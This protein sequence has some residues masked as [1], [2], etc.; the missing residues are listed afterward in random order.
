MS[1][2]T[3]VEKAEK[4]VLSLPERTWDHVYA[5]IKALEA[6][7]T[8]AVKGEPGAPGPAGPPG[9]AGINGAQG[10]RGLQGPPGKDGQDAPALDVI[11]AAVVA[12]LT[13]PAT[14]PPGGVTGTE[15]V[16]NQ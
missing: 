5:K 3:E 10:L 1:V 15:S 4:A 6:R 11:V 2:L 7:L 12:K 16:I 13:P 8:S 14:A 9:P